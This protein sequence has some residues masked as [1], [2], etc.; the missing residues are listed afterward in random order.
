MR[1]EKKGK[2]LFGINGML[3]FLFSVSFLLMPIPARLEGTA[4]TVAMVIAGATFWL[5]FVGGWT[6]WII[7]QITYKN[8]KSKKKLGKR[9]V[10]RIMVDLVFVLAVITFVILNGTG[11]FKGYF[12][13]IDLGLLALSFHMHI[14][15]CG[16][17]YQQIIH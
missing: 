9:N 12:A 4:S 3:W 7:N 15:L 16:K 17:G 1:C 14:L 2:I 10:L 11:L 6:V 5:G 13:Y 8:E